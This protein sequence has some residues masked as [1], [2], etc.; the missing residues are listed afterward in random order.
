ML[1]D[2]A[3]VVALCGLLTQ[4]ARRLRQPAVVAEIARLGGLGW[5]EAASFG[6]LMN[7][8]GLTE[9]VV[10][11]IGRQ[12]GLISGELFTVMVLVA[13]V[14]TAVASPVLRLL[15]VAIAP[16]EPARVREPAVAL[17]AGNTI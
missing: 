14:T 3:I 8:R 16:P 15:G 7:T 2:L 13:L 5:G 10:L 9:I 12:L 6:T 11:G 1:V 17:A 4:L